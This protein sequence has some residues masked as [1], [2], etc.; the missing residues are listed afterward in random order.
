MKMGTVPFRPFQL[1]MGTAPLLAGI[2]AFPMS[3][4]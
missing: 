4:L 1:H 2:L 3:A